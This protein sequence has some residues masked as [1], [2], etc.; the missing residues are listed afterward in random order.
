MTAP[1]LDGGIR[2]WQDQGFDV[3]RLTDARP[4]K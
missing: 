1:T 4:A 3:A 2:A